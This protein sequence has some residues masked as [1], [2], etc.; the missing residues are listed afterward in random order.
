MQELPMSIAAKDV[1]PFTQAHAKL[2]GLA[3]EAL[4]LLL[5]DVKCGLADIAAGRTEDA[6]SAI[7]RLQQRLARR[8]QR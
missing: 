3:D 8:Q 4:L 7:A 1:V 2:S 6:K 5:D